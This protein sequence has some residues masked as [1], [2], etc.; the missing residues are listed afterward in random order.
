MLCPDLDIQKC[1]HI[2]TTL[3][4]DSIYYKKNL[5]RIVS[6]VLTIEDWSCQLHVTRKIFN[7]RVSFQIFEVQSCDRNGIFYLEKNVCYTYVLGC[8]FEYLK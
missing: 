6:N 7:S 4:P 8:M 2:L 5:S 3:C 1:F